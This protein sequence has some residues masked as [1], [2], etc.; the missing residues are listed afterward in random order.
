MQP[1]PLPRHPSS[2]ASTAIANCHRTTSAW[3]W[4]HLIRTGADNVGGVMAARGTNDFEQAVALAMTSPPGRGRC[5][6]TLVVRKVRLKTVYLGVFRSDALERSGLRREFRSPGDWEMNHR[7]R[8]TGGKIWFNPRTGS[9]DPGR[10]FGRARPTVLRVR[11][12][13]SRGTRQ[14][15]RQCRPR[16]CR[17]GLPRLAARR[18]LKSVPLGWSGVMRQVGTP[19]RFRARWPGG[20]LVALRFREIRTGNSA[21][22]STCSGYHAHNLGW[23]PHLSPQRRRR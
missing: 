21:E 18:F 13:A 3:P 14:H 22:G 11:H 15:P 12:V 10:P 5:C 19:G 20:R 23:F 9:T 7:I 8:A 17:L 16:R 4:T 1:S 2:C 6:P